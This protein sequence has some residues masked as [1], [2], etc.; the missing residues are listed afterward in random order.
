MTPP[1]STA[2][3]G[4]SANVLR[5]FEGGWRRLGSARLTAVALAAVCVLVGVYL[6]LGARDAS[7]VRAANQLGLAGD[8]RGA[9]TAA[10]QV[11]RAPASRDAVL[12]QAY[13]D[14]ALGRYPAAS[15]AFHRSLRLDPNN[16]RIYR[17]LATTLLALDA[18][19]SARIEMARALELNPKLVLPVGFVRG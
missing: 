7:R 4:V 9:L 13:A 2:N 10:R 18:R 15:A 11:T 6:T 5:R 17:D 8:Y 12:V 14:V 1:G 3:Y 16:W 19:R